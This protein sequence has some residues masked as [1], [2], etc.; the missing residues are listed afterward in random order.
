[1]KSQ[2]FKHIFGVTAIFL[3]ATVQAQTTERVSVDSFGVQGDHGSSSVPSISADGRFVAFASLAGNLVADDTNGLWDV[4]VHDRHTG[5]TERVS[6][7]SL[8]VQGN[9]DSGGFGGGPSMSPDGRFVA[10][11]SFADNLVPEDTNGVGDVFVHDRESGVTERVSVASDGTQANASSGFFPSISADGRVVSFVS[12]ADN[13]APNDTNG[14]ADV[15]VHDRMTGVTELVSVAIDG[16]AAGA[17][18]SMISA[19]GR[20]VAF[21]SFSDN[22]VSGDTLNTAN[23]F[24]RDRLLGV[25]ERVSMLPDGS[26][27]DP[28]ATVSCCEVSISADGRFV[29]FSTFADGLVPDDADG[30]GDVFVYDRIEK[31]TEL[32]SPPENFSLFSSLSANGRFVSF[33]SLVPGDQDVHI[34]VHDRVLDATTRVSVADDGTPGNDDSFY[35]TI[36]ADGRWVAY[37]SDAD[38]L[39]P[40][41]TNNATDVFVRGP[42]VSLQP[43]DLLADLVDMVITLNL[44]AGISNSL[45]AKLSAV[46]NAFDDLNANNDV[47][48]INAL[49][50][51]IAAVEAQTGNKISETDALLLIAAARQTIALI[52]FT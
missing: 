32:V 23:F 51:F 41:D 24:V 43:V 1:M 20:F 6:V 9:H 28:R 44:Q 25:T 3:M 18:E 42:L 17:T 47:A 29:A 46:E 38:N 48:A 50:A 21:R 49:E 52:E 4:F 10:F 16:T 13:L 15:Y 40:G 14:R 12:G 8:G 31:A 45:D 35:S 36:S 19:D 39:V 26:Q 22:L 27:I 33:F 5:E 37:S 11:G 7:N 2:W 30:L 34:L